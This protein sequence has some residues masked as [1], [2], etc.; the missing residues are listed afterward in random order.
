MPAI[1]EADI[2]KL[3]K[4]HTMRILNTFL[5]LLATLSPFVAGANFIPCL[6][7][8]VP[9]G[10]V[11]NNAAGTS[12]TLTWDAVSGATKYNIE[13]ENASDNPT[14]FHS[15][16]T[17]STHTYTV[18][19]LV[20]NQNYKFKVRT[21]CGSDKSDW[22]EWVFFGSSTGGNGSSSCQVPTG[23]GISIDSTGAKLSWTAVPGATSYGIEIENGSGNSSFLHLTDSSLVNSYLATG[24]LAG[25]NYKFKVRSNCAGGHSDWSAWQNFSSTGGSGSGSSVCAIPGGLSAGNMTT[26]SAIL[27]WND[28]PGASGY[29]IEVEN[30]Q[31]QNVPFSLVQT[32]G[33]NSLLVSGLQASKK[34]KFKVKTQ[35]ANGESDWSNWF[36]FTASTLIADNGSIFNTSFGGDQPVLS[37]KI[38]PNPVQQDAVVR[39][40]GAS[41]ELATV[42]RLY[43]LSGKT[44][45]QWVVESASGYMEQQETFS[46]LQNGIYILHAQNGVQ[47]NSIKLVVSH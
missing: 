7:C 22:S 27:T 3:K 15:V 20:P 17:V 6:S 18:N 33:T 31:N 1:N 39:L 28:V 32:S 23:L 25:K 16:A 21:R 38:A 47:T 34:Y 26:V 35:C 29:I 9:A 44:V 43:D 40:D 19:G 37:L 36:Y 30:V 45:K 12:A 41:D 8:A 4:S 13:V 24:L 11:A 2:V 14:Y 46:E 10:L 5:L 42:I